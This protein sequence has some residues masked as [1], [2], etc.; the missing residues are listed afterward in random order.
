MARWERRTLTNYLLNALVEKGLIKIGNF[1]RSGKKLNKIAY[2][3]TR[4]GIAHRL[5]LTQSYLERKRIEY[6]AL[7][8]EIEILESENIP[9]VQVPA[10]KWGA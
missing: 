9:A 6:E 10:E 2:L 1:H 5:K 7:K 3:L 8:A 4:K